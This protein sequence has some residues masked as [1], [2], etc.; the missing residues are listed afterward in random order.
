MGH[1]PRDFY[2]NRLDERPSPFRIVKRPPSQPAPKAPEQ[3]PL[4]ER[5]TLAHKLIEGAGAAFDQHC[6]NVDNEAMDQQTGRRVFDADE[7]KAR[8]ESFGSRDDVQAGLD[9]AVRLATE[10]RD[11]AQ[12]AV[13]AIRAGLTPERDTAAELKAQRTWS[14]QQRLLDSAETDGQRASIAQ[15]IISNTTDISEFATAVEEIAPYL[16]AHGQPTEWLEDKMAQ[17]VPALSEAKNKL[18]AA[19]S[20]LTVTQ[21]NAN[22]QRRALSSGHRATQLVDPAKVKRRQ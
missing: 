14:R 15:Q 20:A 11:E 9:Q 10:V 1:D 6:R 18:A 19:D 8:V 7:H 2:A 12:T 3:P 5:I 13:N 16:A 21:F 17:R 4:D 22:Q